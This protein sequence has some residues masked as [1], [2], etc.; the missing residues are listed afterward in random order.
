MPLPISDVPCC[1]T[2]LPCAAYQQLRRELM[3]LLVFSTVSSKQA[4]VCCC[5]SLCAAVLPQRCRYL[6]ST[7]VGYAALLLHLQVIAAADRIHD[8]TRFRAQKLFIQVS[9][10]GCHSC[11]LGAMHTNRCVDRLRHA[12][13]TLAHS[14]AWTCRCSRLALAPVLCCAT[15]PVDELSHGHVER[16]LDSTQDNTIITGC[17]RASPFTLTAIGFLRA[18]CHTCRPLYFPPT[19]CCTRVSCTPFGAVGMAPHWLSGP[20]SMKVIRE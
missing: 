15:S 11:S 1:H 3:C 12:P 10:T 2:P 19:P 6:H 13:H 8:A 14:Q 9:C 20:S 7:C 5:M 18:S 4:S 16:Q 17:C